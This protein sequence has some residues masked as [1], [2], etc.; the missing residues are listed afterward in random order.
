[1]FAKQNRAEEVSPCAIIRI[2]AP[3][4]PHGVWIKIP[5][6]TRPMWLTEE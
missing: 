6:T 1:M 4:N 5:P 2:S 3:V